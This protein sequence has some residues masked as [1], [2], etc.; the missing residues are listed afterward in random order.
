MRPDERRVMETEAREF[1]LIE[2]HLKLEREKRG[3]IQ[4]ARA[5]GE[6]LLNNPVQAAYVRYRIAVN[7]VSKLLDVTFIEA[8]KEI[9]ALNE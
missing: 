6:A 4:E 8:V 5:L 3:A 2:K 1:D 7:R 9:R